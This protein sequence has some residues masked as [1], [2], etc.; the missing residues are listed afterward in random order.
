M[1][2]AHGPQITL[3][4]Y[5]ST[6]LVSIQAPADQKRTPSNICCVVDTSGS[7]NTDATLKA[8]AGAKSEATGL[9]VL[10]ITKHSV[11]TIISSLDAHDRLSIVEFST[12]ARVVFQSTA[13]TTDGQAKAKEALEKLR[14]T[15][16]TNLWDGLVKGLEHAAQHKGHNDALLLL[17][18]GEPTE[19][20]PGG[21]Q[22]YAKCLGD[23]L[24]KTNHSCPISTFGFGYSLNSLL[25][26]EIS[27]IGNGK[28]AFIPDS[29]LVGTVFVNAISNILA[30]YANDAHLE[31]NLG[32]SLMSK[33]RINKDHVSGFKITKKDKSTCILFLGSIL[34]GQE[35]NVVLEFDEPVDSNELASFKAELKAK[36]AKR[37][38]QISSVAS[39]PK[40]CDD[41]GK[42]QVKA[43]QFRV[44]LVELVAQIMING[45]TN[46]APSNQ[47]IKLFIEKMEKAGL[48]GFGAD[49]LKDVDGQI[50]EAI[51]KSEWFKKWG[52]HYLP[53]LAGAHLHQQCN[54]FKDPGV[55][56]YGGPLFSDLRDTIDDIFVK[57]PPPTPSKT[58]PTY[59]H[60]Q[61]NATYTPAAVDMN[62]YY[63]AS[64]G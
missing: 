9:S 43:Q 36:C 56:H 39:A 8:E 37:G 59:S 15:G 14:P 1:D 26:N 27:T 40:P 21:A 35:K 18:D 45:E 60:S 53:S 2:T 19:H 47:L 16:C 32:D 50:S 61:T 24:H 38:N 41:E 13:M 17:T 12:N 29:G 46:L 5:G 51:S 44:E 34:V 22:A 7:M 58:Q 11:N 54:N 30:N 3:S 20:P 48:E 6:V 64:C 62:A 23:L 4:N 55:Q 42:A 10:D 63:N 31:L 57:L 25:L 52:R 49:L 33:L 28:Y